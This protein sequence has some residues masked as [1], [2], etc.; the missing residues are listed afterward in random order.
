MSFCERHGNELMFDRLSAESFDTSMTGE[1]LFCATNG[2]LERYVD[3]ETQLFSKPLLETL[4]MT[5]HVLICMVSDE[6]EI[7][8]QV[9]AP[10]LACI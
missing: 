1:L 5:F 6:Q 2:L 7:P 3:Q 9:V 10:V 4:F 8:E